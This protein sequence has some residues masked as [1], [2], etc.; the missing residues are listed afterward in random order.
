MLGGPQIADCATRAGSPS[1]SSGLQSVPP[2][3]RNDA[4]GRCEALLPRGAEDSLWLPRAANRPF[5]CTRDGTH[6]TRATARNGARRRRS[7]P[8]TRGSREQAAPLP[9]VAPR[10][11]MQAMASSSE[12]TL[13]QQSSARGPVGVTA[14]A[15]AASN[16]VLRSAPTLA[17]E[18]RPVGGLTDPRPRRLGSPSKLD[19]P[20]AWT[21]QGPCAL[22]LPGGRWVAPAV[23]VRLAT[24]ACRGYAAFFR[25]PVSR[26]HRRPPSTPPPECSSRAGRSSVDIAVHD[27]AAR[28]HAWDA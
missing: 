2:T 3:A 21:R 11:I 16:R 25:R 9:H 8:P 15:S 6:W 23:P 7:P 26:I 5:I 19:L 1:R 27:L 14:A 28:G 18:V 20:I 24:S 10:S 12:G 17:A 22:D 4:A 13:G